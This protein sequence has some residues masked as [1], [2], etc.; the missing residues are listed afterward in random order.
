MTARTDIAAIDSQWSQNKALEYITT[1]GYSRYP[2]YEETIDRVTGIVHTKDVITVLT[3]GR[4]VILED[5]VRP[6]MFVPDSQ[7]LGP[8]LRKMQRRQEHM[9]IVLDEFGGTAGLITLEDLLEEIVGE[10]RDEHD[11]EIPEFSVD[12]SGRARIAG[13]MPIDEFNEFYR[14][15]LDESVA[16]TVA[17][18]VVRILGHIPEEGEVVESGGVQLKVTAVHD[19]RIEWIEGTHLT[20]P[21][22][23]EG[24][25]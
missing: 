8:L 11:V 4:V 13:K 25:S 20:Q 19:N 12:E 9:G 7:K 5:L 3:S 14:A 15:K 16:D 21:E 18:Y 17:G 1:E 23:E 6:A 22:T 24:E 2:V 10:I